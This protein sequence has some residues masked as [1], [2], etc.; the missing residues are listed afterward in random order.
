VALLQYAKW[1]WFLLALLDVLLGRRVSYILTPKVKSN[2][3]NYLL[4]VPN[5]LVIVVL[6][7]AWVV[8]QTLGSAVHPVVY[9]CALLFVIASMILIWTDFWDFPTPYQKE[10]QK[11]RGLK[12]STPSVA[13]QLE[14]L[15]I[16]TKESLAG[17]G[18]DKSSAAT[19]RE[20]LQNRNI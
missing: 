3:R 6:C 13:E 5:L 2:S 18:G 7:S 15:F 17:E 11:T 4:L 10:F 1:P 19:R 12:V 16:H 9:I 14:S 20:A 8:G